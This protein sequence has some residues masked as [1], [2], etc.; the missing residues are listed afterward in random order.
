M[1]WYDQAGT[2]RLKARG[3]Y[4]AAAKSYKLTVSQTVPPTPNQ[5]E[6]TPF[7]FRSASASSPPMARS[8]RRIWVMRM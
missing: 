4:D 1:R 7:R 3:V 2:P 6:K 8:W 5:T